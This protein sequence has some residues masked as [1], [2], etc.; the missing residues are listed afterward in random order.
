MDKSNKMKMNK[1]GNADIVFLVDTSGSM[2]AKIEAV[3]HSCINFADK[4]INEGIDVRLGLVGFDIGGHCKSE[5]QNYKVHKLSVYTI[6]VWGM[7]NPTEFKSDIKTLFVGLFGG[8]GCYIANKDT[9]DI[10]P[11]VVDVFNSQSKNTKILVIISDEMGNND[12]LLQIINLLIANNIVTY[13]LGVSYP[14]DGAHCQIAQR[15]GGEFWDIRKNNGVQDFSRLL[16]NIAKIIVE[17]LTNSA[18]SATINDATAILQYK[19]K[20]SGLSSSEIESLTK[21]QPENPKFTF[22]EK[23]K[24]TYTFGTKIKKGGKI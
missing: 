15:T 21:S 9:V 2:S 4:I 11:Y 17:D 19:M 5:S 3:K 22:G 16:E 6:G 18:N 1:R 13:V 20:K 24:P 7:K 12:G 14:Q 23:E 10:F 8:A